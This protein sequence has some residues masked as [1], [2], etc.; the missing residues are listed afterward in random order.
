MAKH[1]T[2]AFFIPHRGC[3]HQCSFCDQRTI[4]GTQNAPEPMEI[5]QTCREML[6]RSA[7]LESAEIAFFGGSFTAVE[8]EYQIALLEAA[9]PFLG[10]GKFQGIRIS[11]RPDAID[12]EV[13]ERLKQYHVTAIELGAQSMSDAV[14][15]ANARGHTAQAVRDASA[16]IRSAGFSL[17]LQQMVGLYGSTL[18]DEY[19]TLEE[20]LRCRPDTMRIY[21]TVVLEGTKLA[22][23][24]QDGVYPVLTQEE[25]LEF[26]A[27]ALCRCA[28]EGVRVIRLGLHDTPSIRERM[29][30][31]YYHPAYRELVESRLYRRVLEQAAE[32]DGKP[33]LFVETALGTLSKLLGQH[34]CNRKWLAERGVTLK[35]VETTDVLSGKLR[36][37]KRSY[38]LFS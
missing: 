25:V 27:D 21:P 38:D 15:T 35:A 28:Q 11:T 3:P 6:E 1:K 19:D 14:L 33:E 9:Q 24:C 32:D 36:V 5:A 4:S 34:G 29:I 20:L 26:C 12:W 2:L 23:C 18:A 22:E 37:G 31:G 17:G 13:L 16:A 7:P 30:A 10:A 8:T